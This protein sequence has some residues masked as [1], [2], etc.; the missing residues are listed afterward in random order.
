MGNHPQMSAAL[1]NVDML[2]EVYRNF[3][4]TD[5]HTDGDDDDD[6]E[7]KKKKEKKREKRKEKKMTKKLKKREK[8]A[9]KKKKKKKKS[10]SSSSDDDSDDD[11]DGDSGESSEE[12]D[13]TTN[14]DDS[15][16]TPK[17]LLE[18]GRSA[19]EAMQFILALFPE[20]RGDLRDLLKNVDDGNAVPI[21]GIPDEIMK[22]LLERVFRNV[23][24]IKLPKLGAWTLTKKRLKR[25]EFTFQKVSMAFNVS[26]DKLK[27]FETMT[28]PWV[29]EELELNEAKLKKEEKMMMTMKQAAQ[30]NDGDFLDNVNL[31]GEEAEEMLRKNGQV[32]DVDSDDDERNAEED[33]EQSQKKE[34]TLKFKEKTTK[35]SEEVG[36]EEIFGKKKQLGPMAPPKELLE[37][38]QRQQLE[39]TNKAFGFGP[40]P[41]DVVEFVDSKSAESRNAAARRIIS[42]LKNNGDAYDVLSASPENSN[43]DLKKIYWKLSL[44]IHPDKCE[45]PCAANA[46]D[47]V[48]KAYETL[49]DEAQRRVLDEKRKG[50]LDREEFDAWLKSEREKAV[51]RK[52]RGESLPG[53][54]E[55]LS[56]T[57][58]KAPG[59][60]KDGGEVREEWMTSLPPERKAAQGPPTASVTAFARGDGLM[61]RDQATIDEWTRNPKDRPSETTLFLQQQE[62]IY[63]LPNAVATAKKDEERKKMI[64]DYNEGAGRTKSL[65]NQHRE[66]LKGNNS[67]KKRDRKINSSK[68]EEDV[69]SS[70]EDGGDDKKKKK[71]KK[72]TEE[73]NKAKKSKDESTD[74]E[75]DTDGTGWTY[76]PFNRDTDLKISKVGEDSPREAMKRAGGGLSSRFGAGGIQ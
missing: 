16:L 58:D 71:K 47:A 37:E 15:G 22:M 31:T 13:D 21:D 10:S 23:G 8:K 6:D 42:V 54:E 69:N 53:D 50:E 25:R 59:A 52:S 28:L 12:N 72:K 67:I 75:G 41:P 70:G 39:M 3:R 45:E 9:Q 18:R 29:R 63:S 34:G 51:W 60:E 11:S 20:Q 74:K 35:L 64:D 49:K 65:L 61:V 46:F 36:D 57:F 56:G 48:K 33:N 44:I 38:M 17:V 30:K 62:K 1:A 14:E 76:R 19:I 26:L 7:T 2:N 32:V 4:S 5:D 73:M 43:A 66:N 40:P 27:T 24:M 55:I 68:K